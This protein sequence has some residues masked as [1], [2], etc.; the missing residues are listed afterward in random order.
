MKN[1]PLRGD[2]PIFHFPLI[3]LNPPGVRLIP[4]AAGPSD[5][6]SEQRTR[7]RGAASGTMSAPSAPQLGTSSW[8][9]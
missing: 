3:L 7:G 1:P 8:M 2:F 5:A 9:T 4:M 6:P